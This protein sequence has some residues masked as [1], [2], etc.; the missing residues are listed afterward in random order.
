MNKNGKLDANDFAM[1]RK[2]GKKEVTD[3]GWDDMLKDVERRRSATK[4]GEV[5][6]GHKHDIT[7]TGTGRRVQRRTDPNTGYSKSASP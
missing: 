3:E 7:D 6:H 1:L 5:T 4:K 2:G